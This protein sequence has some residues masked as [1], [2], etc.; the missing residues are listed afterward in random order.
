MIGSARRDVSSSIPRPVCYVGEEENVKG[1]R[2]WLTDRLPMSSTYGWE[3]VRLA[4]APLCFCVP[5]SYMPSE[6]PFDIAFISVYTEAAIKTEDEHRRPVHAPHRTASRGVRSDGAPMLRASSRWKPSRSATTN[7]HA[8]I[9]GARLITVNLV[10]IACRGVQ[11]H[12]A[13]M[14]GGR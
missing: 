8:I 12:S 7:A 4:S 13:F 6:T 3:P 2:I 9:M 5:G 11:P 14:Q 10:W 1:G